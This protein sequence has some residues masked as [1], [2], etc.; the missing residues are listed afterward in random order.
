MFYSK[1]IRKSIF[2]ILLI[3]ISTFEL[4]AIVFERRKSF[5]DDIFEYYFL[6]API[7]RPGTGSFLSLGAF[8]NNIEVPWI[9]EGRFNF[10]G[11]ESVKLKGSDRGSTDKYIITSKSGFYKDQGYENYS[12]V[13]DIS[14]IDGGKKVKIKFKSQDCIPPKDPKKE[15]KIYDKWLVKGFE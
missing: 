8:I 10:I 7:E 11:E 4:F 9:D 5:N 12:F 3:N 2:V 15:K 1:I 14:Y 6:L 13:G